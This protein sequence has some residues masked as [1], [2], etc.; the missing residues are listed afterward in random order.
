M[1]DPPPAANPFGARFWFVVASIPIVAVDVSVIDALLPDII[2]QLGISVADASLVDASTVTVAGALMVPVGKLGD[3]VGT[4]RVLVAG[5]VI[6]II[7]GLLT[8]LANGLGLL[9]AGRITQGAAFAMAVTMGLATL[10]REYPQQGPARRRAFALYVAV[11][12]CSLGFAPVVGA[13]LAEYASWR[14]AF[15]I[16]SPL[17]AVV[18]IGIQRTIPAAP[19]AVIKQSF[20]AL[21][22]VL[23]VITVGLF[24]FAIQQGSRYGWWQAAAG[25]SFLG[26]PWRFALSPTPVLF[27]VAVLLLG[28]FLLVEQ[29]RAGRQLDV[30]IDFRLFHISNYVSGSLAVALSSSAS[31]GALLMVSLYAEYVM[32]AGPLVAGLI[33]M[34]L[35][36]AVLVTGPIGERLARYP[37]R[38][39]GLLGFAVQ[40][41]AVIVLVAASTREGQP[42]V[43]AAAMFVLGVAWTLALSSL[44]SVILASVPAQLAGEAVG[45]QTA[46]RYLICGFAMVVM[47]TLMISVAAFQVQKMGLA[48]LTPADR[49]TID[50][51]ERLS[52]PAASRPVAREGSAAQRAEGERFDQDLAKLRGDIDDGIRAAGFFTIFMLVLSLILGWRL[53]REAPAAPAPAH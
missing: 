18:A 41:V 25:I 47:T 2:K 36:F 51:V 52:R 48:G 37:G 42:V 40:L 53:P 12:I 17:A 11:A 22:A 1:A 26:H 13:F 21:G 23:L 29:W 19:K 8:G 30:V 4:K 15:L 31:V 16:V 10:T 44:T 24:L 38:T 20:D 45:V 33:V 39:T 28:V 32:N 50:A 6:A 14:W 27:V 7:G 5:M 34:P 9:L 49:K 3:L 46:S 35:G 43:L